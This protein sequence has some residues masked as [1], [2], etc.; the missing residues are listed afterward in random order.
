MVGFNY[1]YAP[2]NEVWGNDISGK[3][4]KKG[5]S[6]VQD[7]VCD[8]YEMKGN[9][10]AYSE[11]E[12]VNYV[13]DKSRN[14]RTVNEKPQQV[15]SVVVDQEHEVY[16]S[17][18]LPKSLF[19][20]QFDV[21]HPGNFDMEDPKE[22]M[23]RACHTRD[24]EG[25][26]LQED[27]KKRQVESRQWEPPTYDSD[28]EDERPRRRA[29]KEVFYEDSQKRHF[30]D[31]DDDD[32]ESPPPRPQRPK[33]ERKRFVEDID[34]DTEWSAPPQRKRKPRYVYLDI[35]LYVLSGIILIF[36]LEQFVKIGINMQMV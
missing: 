7:P 12:L 23:V 10:S 8:L 27:A 24:D 1:G 35:L 20:S 25:E 5:K 21:K 9:S 17:K 11:T 2:L 28:V 32:N 19:E 30:Y 6:P 13:Y 34:S 33:Q 16:D 15:R 4:K 14:Q 26:Y 29:T 3:K 22:Y 31:D 18:P 36:L